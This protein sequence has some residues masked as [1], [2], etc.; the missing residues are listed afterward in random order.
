VSGP[1]PN[2]TTH[3]AVAALTVVAATPVATPVAAT[4]TLTG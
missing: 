3:Q 4:P 2:G 1:G